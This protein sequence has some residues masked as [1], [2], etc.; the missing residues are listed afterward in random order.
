MISSLRGTVLAVSGGTAVIE[1]GGVGLAVQLTQDHA[2]SLRVGERA[3]VLTSLI[4][5][6]E[7]LSLFG[8]VDK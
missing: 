8:F 6:E 3:F 7:S 1:V 5:R 4:V 2:L